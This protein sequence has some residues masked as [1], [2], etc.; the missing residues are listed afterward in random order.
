MWTNFQNWDVSKINTLEGETL[1]ETRG[2]M[3]RN[4]T[5]FNREIFLRDNSKVY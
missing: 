4:W 1:E 3:E 5:S 2:R